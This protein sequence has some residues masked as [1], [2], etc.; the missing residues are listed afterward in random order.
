M[1]V[2]SLPG[3]Q[4]VPAEVGGQAIDIRMVF[5]LGGAGLEHGVVDADV[6]AARVKLAKYLFEARCLVGVCDLMQKGRGLR[7]MLAD[8]VGAGS[9]C[10]QKKAAIPVIRAG[11]QEL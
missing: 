4:V 8:G 3:A 2:Q 11:E 7:K 10:P 6:F 9:R 1:F 5:A